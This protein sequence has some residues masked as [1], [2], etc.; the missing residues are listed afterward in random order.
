MKKIVLSLGGSLIVPEKVQGHFL[1][2]FKA[3]I[4]SY[5]DTM[6]FVIFTGGG[7]TA[8]LYQ[9]GVQ[10]A[11]INHDSDSLDWIGIHA[12]RLNAALLQLIFEKNAAREIIEDPT[13]SVELDTPIRIGAGWKPGWSTDYD[14]VAFAAGHGISRV[15]NL[16]NIAYAYDK[17]PKQFD[18]ARPIEEIE[19]ADFRSIVGDVWKPGLNMPFD[20]IASQLAQ[21]KG[22]EVIIADGTNLSNLVAIIEEKPFTGTRIY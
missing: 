14:A 21:E 22:I 2:D 7:N 4:E 16:S 6:Q 12:S 18:D 20:P 8:R 11:L 15:V 13:L 10:D 5:I 9:E 1:H 3:C 19:W 17:D